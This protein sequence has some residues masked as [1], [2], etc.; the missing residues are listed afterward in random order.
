VAVPAT[1]RVH[2]AGRVHEARVGDLSERGLRLCFEHEVPIRPGDVIDVEL[3]VAEQAPMA[4]RA[5]VV[6]H[7]TDA[8]GTE[9]GGRLVEPPADV[10]RSLGAVVAARLGHR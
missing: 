3:A 6:H 8:A 9:I 2:H 1:A 4:M 5:Q 7:S 10:V